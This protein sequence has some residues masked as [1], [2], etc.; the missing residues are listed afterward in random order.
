MDEDVLNAGFQAQFLDFLA[1]YEIPVD[2]TAL[3]AV[4]ALN[5]ECLIFFIVGKF[6]T[7]D[8]AKNTIDISVA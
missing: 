2:F 3:E 5:Q 1:Q 4:R 6:Y 8:K 7:K